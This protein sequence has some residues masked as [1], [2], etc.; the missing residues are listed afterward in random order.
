M[1][2]E[3]ILKFKY[4]R[5]GSLDMDDIYYQKI[6]KFK[7]VFNECLSKS[8][9]ENSCLILSENLPKNISEVIITL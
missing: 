2:V 5:K 4:F 7:K 1:F 9:K 3:L 8:K 6:Q